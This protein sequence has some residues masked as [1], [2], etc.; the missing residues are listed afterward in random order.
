MISQDFD[1]LT[2]RVAELILRSRR[3]VVF[4]GAGI[5]TESGIPDFRGPGGLW[6]KYDPEIFTIQRFL[7]DS[8]A[9]RTYW[10]LRGSGEFM[11]S[12]IQPNPAHYALAE[13]EKLGK[14]DC[15]ITQNVDDLHE[16]AGNSP[17][18]V[19]HLHGTM[20][21]VKCLQCGN[22]YLMD[23]VYRWIAGGM[24]VPDCPECGGILKPQVV[25][26]GE[27][28]P[29]WETA[30]AQRRC[31]NCDLCI[32]IGSSL[33]VYPAALMPQYAVRSGASLVIINR[34]P[35]DLDRSADVC[36]HEGAGKAMSAIMTIVKEKA[37][38]NG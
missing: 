18:K 22:Q 14:L 32:V 12:D 28:M 6:S 31:E 37:I 19:I 1:R 10:K 4:T 3:T 30:E 13:L 21:K 29:V 5:S 7:R 33:V 2:R 9:R 16:R 26:F 24:E 8:E 27:A 38:N 25:F 11:H 36:I 35:T 15:V 17:N 20:E 23:E 34:E